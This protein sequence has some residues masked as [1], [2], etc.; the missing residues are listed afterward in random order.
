MRAGGLESDRNSQRA[1][2]RPMDGPAHRDLD[3]L[4]EAVYSAAFERDWQHFQAEALQRF[5]EWAGADGGAWTIRARDGAD[6][7]FARW[8]EQLALDAATLAGLRFPQGQRELQIGVD[9][10][11]RPRQ[12]LALKI[13][14]RGSSLH[15]VLV[16]LPGP[17]TPPHEWLRRA[18]GHLV[19]AASLGLQQFV[20]RDEWLMAMGRS[21]RGSAALVD[22]GGAIYAISDRFRELVALEF[23][24]VH[25]TALPFALPPERLDEPGPFQIGSLHFRVKPEGRLY[26]LNARRPHPLDVLS[27]REQ[28]IARAL[29]LGKTFKSV[30]REYEIAISTVANH[31]SRIYRKL[32]IYRREELVELLRRAADSKAA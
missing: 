5:C 9:V 6:G 15:S 25:F 22:A 2:P 17:Q 29:A 3:R 8:P 12:A 30:A 10:D 18:A 14:H 24:D 31:A 26:L 32:G 20:R 16:L 13:G 7:E 27:P 4:I 23:G 21:S 11:G 28:E 19:Q 1:E